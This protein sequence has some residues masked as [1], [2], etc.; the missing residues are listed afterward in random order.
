MLRV[1]GFVG[2]VMRLVMDSPEARR[3]SEMWVGG[4]WA[5]MYLEIEKSPRR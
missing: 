2:S 1:P 4:C 3:S 5:W